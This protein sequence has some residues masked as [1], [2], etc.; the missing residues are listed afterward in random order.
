MARKA[1][2]PA[3]RPGLSRHCMNGATMKK[4]AHI[5]GIVSAP[6]VELIHS[7]ASNATAILPSLN[8]LMQFIEVFMGKYGAV[9]N[10][11]D[12]IANAA[13]AALTNAVI[14]GNHENPL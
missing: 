1:M 7:L 13:R 5:A 4:R 3:G 10:N 6:S 14:H 8:R 12:E 9:N 11:Q 2:Y